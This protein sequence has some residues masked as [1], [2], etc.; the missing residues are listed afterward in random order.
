MRGIAD[1]I[2]AHE[3][4]DEKIEYRRADPSIFKNEG[5]PT[6]AEEFSRFNVHFLKADNNRPAGWQ[7]VRLRLEEYEGAPLLQ[8]FSTC[9]HLIRTL[10]ALQHDPVKAEDLDTTGEDH[11]ADA[12]RYGLMSRPYFRAAPRQQE[13]I[14]GIERASLE[15]LWKTQPTKKRVW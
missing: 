8:I 4:P 5:G 15:E 12:L 9:K 10:P 6:I 14:R 1:M 13:P 3:L 7:Q 11:A 2:R